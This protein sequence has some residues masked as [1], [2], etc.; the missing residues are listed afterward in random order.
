MSRTTVDGDPEPEGL[1]EAHLGNDPGDVSDLDDL[2]R[3]ALEAF[4][5][6]QRRSFAGDSAAN[7]KLPVEALC[8]AVV[9]G[10]PTLVLITPWT[11][12]GLV[13]PVG[14]FPDELVVAGRPR[15]VFAGDVAPLGPYRSVGLVPD[16]SRLT[17]PEQARTLARSFAAPFHDAVRAALAAISRR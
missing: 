10:M 6:V 7:P 2:V 4:R 9:A 11:L 8:P 1:P 16:V 17:R 3:R 12:N 5:D 14:E 13:F 15:P